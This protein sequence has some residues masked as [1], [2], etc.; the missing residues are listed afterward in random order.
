M[1]KKPEH[2]DAAKKAITYLVQTELKELRARRVP[3]AALAFT[4]GLQQD[5]DDYKVD[6]IHVKVARTIKGSKA[7]DVIRFVKVLGPA[8]ARTVSGT[9]PEEINISAYEEFLKNTLIQVLDCIGLD[10]SSVGGEDC[11]TTLFGD[12]PIRKPTALQSQKKG[13]KGVHKGMDGRVRKA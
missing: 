3:V 6:S 13:K 5:P 11:Q 10:W 9:R 8:G 1:M 2:L 12:K 7:G 4:M